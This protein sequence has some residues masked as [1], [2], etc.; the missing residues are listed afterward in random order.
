[1]FTDLRNNRAARPAPQGPGVQLTD[2]RMGWQHTFQPNQALIQNSNRGSSQGPINNAINQHGI[3]AVWKSVAGKALGWPK[4][5]QQNVTGLQQLLTP[6][7]FCDVKYS[8]ATLLINRLAA[9]G[10][11]QL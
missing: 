11:K 7:L 4:N 10:W 9:N 5:Q 1:M 2:A 6:A 8:A 3:D